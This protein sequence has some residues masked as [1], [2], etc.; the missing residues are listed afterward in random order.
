MEPR[1]VLKHH[2]NSF[3][4]EE[5]TLDLSSVVKVGRAVAKCK[6]QADNA[7]FDCKV[8][9]R[10]HALL[11][12]ADGKFL[13]KDTGSSN[14]TFIN[15]SRLSVANEESMPKEI[16]SNDIIQFGVEVV[17]SASKITH[18]CIIIKIKLYHPNG[19]EALESVKMFRNI[20]TLNLLPPHYSYSQILER[21]A[22]IFR[23]LNKI[24]SILEDAHAM[25]DLTLSAKLEE[26]KLVCKVNELQSLCDEQII[27]T[28]QLEQK[29]AEN[30]LNLHDTS[31]KLELANQSIELLKVKLRDKE[32][33]SNELIIKSEKRVCSYFWSFMAMIISIIIFVLLKFNE[34]IFIG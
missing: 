28:K 13:L 19:S 1:A 6:P 22:Q 12:F 23:K 24:E 21:E 32:I 27:L 5:R 31:S 29:L 9:S 10:N 34:Y 8:L 14:G 17:D 2:T 4:F 26:K 18:G 20:R 30:D 16:H 11:K 33:E 15:S 3:P 25:A 7:I